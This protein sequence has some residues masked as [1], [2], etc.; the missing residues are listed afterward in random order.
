M[1]LYS[2]LVS[3]CGITGVQYGF[4]KEGGSERSIST[5]VNV[6]NYFFNRQSD[7]YI[8]T[9]DATAAFDRVNAYGLLR[10]FIDRGIA[11][12]IIRVLHSLY[13]SSQACVS[14]MGYCTQYVDIYGGLEQGSIL[15]SLF[16]NVYVD[17]LM[18]QLSCE[19]LG[20]TIGG[21]YYGTIFYA[22]DIVFVRCFGTQNAENNWHLL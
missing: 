2:K 13:C 17:G 3:Y 20:C 19:K 10:K 11:F 21:I 15:S 12:D 8:V 6:V 16:Y 9:L 14:I 18:K 7:V 22:D 4:E 1:C 5:V